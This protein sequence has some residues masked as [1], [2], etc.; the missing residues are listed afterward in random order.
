MNKVTTRDKI[1]L[2][3]IIVLVIGYGLFFFLYKPLASETLEN[4][5]ILDEYQ[6]KQ[7]SMM[8][9]ISRYGTQD[10]TINELKDNINEKLNTVSNYRTNEDLEDYVVLLADGLDVEVTD[11]TMSDFELVQMDP[12]LDEDSLTMLVSADESET[13]ISSYLLKDYVCSIND[14]T[15]GVY[16][17][18]AIPTV[19]MEKNSI[20]IS[21]TTSEDSY[22]EFLNRILSDNKT[23]VLVDTSKTVNDDGEEYQL[24]LDVYSIKGWGEVN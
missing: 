9:T 6:I 13:E 14:C 19:S 16:H 22:K 2:S 1:L 12:I 24:M 5:A 17:E 3:I 7:S 10:E 4:S 21:F 18:S 8:E 15:D 11:L 23:M 20:S